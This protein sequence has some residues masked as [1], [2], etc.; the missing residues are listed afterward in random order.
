M[1]FRQ[2]S[3]FFGPYGTIS[4]FKNHPVEEEKIQGM[5]KIFG[6]NNQHIAHGRTKKVAWFVSNCHSMS[7]RENYVRKLQEHIEVVSCD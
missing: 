3:T 7:G 5:I 6:Q 4:S 2:D 1:T